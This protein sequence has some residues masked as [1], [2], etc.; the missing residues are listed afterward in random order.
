FKPLWLLTS[1]ISTYQLGYIVTMQ[2]KKAP[3]V[4][5]QLT[6]PGQNYNEYSLVLDKQFF[7][8]TPAGILSDKEYGLLGKH[9]MKKYNAFIKTLA[10]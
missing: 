1:K 3:Q 9:N 4:F 10:D 2:D 7:S 6:N 5:V 8:S